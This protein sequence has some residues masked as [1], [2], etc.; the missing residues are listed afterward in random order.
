M[1][2][3]GVTVYTFSTVKDPFTGRFLGIASS[4]TKEG[5]PTTIYTV[6]EHG[7]MQDFNDEALALVGIQETMT[8]AMNFK[9][10]HPDEIDRK[11]L[12][13]YIKETREY[14]KHR[15]ES[16]GASEDEN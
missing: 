12:G 10:S 16:P 13:R 8:A 11:Q 15:R 14:E 3:D 9:F 1:S 2:S 7:N 6:D 5:I 4:T